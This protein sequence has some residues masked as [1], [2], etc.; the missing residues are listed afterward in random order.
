M[1][2]KTATK[3]PRKTLT[4]NKTSAKRVVEKSGVKAGKT[5]KANS[6]AKPAKAPTKK[7]AIKNA[8]AGEAKTVKAISKSVKN[9]DAATTAAVKATKE[10][11]AAAALRRAKAADDR[12]KAGKAKRPVIK[13]PTCADNAIG[14]GAPAAIT[15]PTSSDTKGGAP[16]SM[17]AMVPLLPPLLSDTGLRLTEDR[18]VVAM[19]GASLVTPALRADIE[20]MEAS[21]IGVAA[22]EGVIGV[23]LSN[24]EVRARSRGLTPSDIPIKIGNLPFPKRH[25]HFNESGGLTKK[26]VFCMNAGSQIRNMQRQMAYEGKLRKAQQ[27]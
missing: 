17:G 13:D 11:T 21:A 27:L 19:D 15:D 1:T 14:G 20:A 9:L 2:E 24:D 25:R 3:A 10:F 8:I 6:A 18:R 5:M 7:A 23:T 16:A 22:K 4:L 12:Q 26:Q